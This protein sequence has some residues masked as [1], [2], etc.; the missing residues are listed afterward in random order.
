MTQIARRNVWQHSRQN[1]V[2]HS[3][4]HVGQAEIAA[5]EFVGQAFV[6]DAEQMPHRRL[7]VVDGVFGRLGCADGATPWVLAA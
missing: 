2:D 5:L 7:E 3:A 6:V 1:L 4:M